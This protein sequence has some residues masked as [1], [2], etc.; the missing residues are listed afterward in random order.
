MTKKQAHEMY[1]QVKI[2]IPAC[3]KS[4]EIAQD[5]IGYSPIQPEVPEIID[6]T[7]LILKGINKLL[8]SLNNQTNE[9]HFD[10]G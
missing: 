1:E 2:M 8:N 5:M 6:G 7:E 3:Q 10:N 4:M 9:G